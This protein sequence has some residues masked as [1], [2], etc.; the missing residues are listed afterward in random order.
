MITGSC[1]CS[2]VKFAV[3][4]PLD[5]MSHCHCSMCRKLHG[6]AFA[7]YGVGAANS[8]RWLEGEAAIRHYESSP[9]A[10]RAFCGE[11]GSV[12]P[13]IHGTMV[14]VPVGNLDTDAG[15]QP[16][17][18]IFAGSMA[19]WHA[20]GDGLPRFDTW[21]KGDSLPAGRT[22]VPRGE[23]PQVL[24]G[25]CQCGAV[26]FQVVEP[27][28]RAHNCHCSRCRKGRSA[29][30]ASNAFTSVDGVRFTRGEDNITLYRLPAAK[31]FSIAFCKS[32]GSGVPRLDPE[33]K[34]AVI[35]MGALDDDPK[36]GVDSNIFTA[37]APAWYPAVG[38]IPAF[39]GPPA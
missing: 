26:H 17:C 12:L 7:T 23:Q 5:R 34:I 10:V 37:D 16:S 21:P 15:M 6:A 1:L 9:G 30:H 33:R 27:F 19:P 36:R 11:C 38:D 25:G 8:L 18:H 13:D 14:N 29:A 28:I 31:F 22:T 24:E 4:R 32:C 35:P 2:A 20:I 39:D 3:D